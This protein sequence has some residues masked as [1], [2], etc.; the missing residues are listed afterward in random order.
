VVLV[1]GFLDRGSL[2][3]SLAKSLKRS[4]ICV[5]VIDLHPSHAPNGIEPLGEQLGDFVEDQV[6]AD[7][8]C[9]LLGFSMGGLVS[10]Y[11]LQRLGGESRVDRLITLSTPH[12]GTYTAGALPFF[13][14]CRQMLPGSAWLEA[15]NRDRNRLRPLH[16]LSFWT[17]YDL[18]IRPPRHAILDVGHHR[19]MPVWWHRGMPSH[20]GVT[21]EVIRALQESVDGP[22]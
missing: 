17:P 14:G 20:P 10:R 7:H 12:F 19:S 2:F 15:L 18:T 16:P 13:K 22:G 21:T 1:H 5:H 4:G 3:A 6:P 11:Y 8:P 9:A